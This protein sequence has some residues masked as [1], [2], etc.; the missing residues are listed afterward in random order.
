MKHYNPIIW[1]PTNKTQTNNISNIT[2]ITYNM[3]PIIWSPNNKTQTNN[4]S[5]IHK[6]IQHRTYTVYT[7]KLNINKLQPFVI[8]RIVRPR[9]FESKFRSRCAKKLVGA[10]RKPTSFM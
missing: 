10:L 7:N 6:H 9:I 4:I 3:N 2:L 5:K 8:L 1:S